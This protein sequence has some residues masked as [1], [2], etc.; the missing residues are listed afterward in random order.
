MRQHSRAVD[1]P[2]Q[3]TDMDQSTRTRADS[4]SKSCTADGCDRALRA[5]GMCSTHYNQASTTRHKKAMVQCVVCGTH[6]AKHSAGS[7]QPVCGDACRWWVN[8]MSVK[9][10]PVPRTHRAHPE[11]GSLVVRASIALSP[12]PERVRPFVSVLCVVCH[13][14]YLARHAGKY[15]SLPCLW[16]AKGQA[17]RA[18]MCGAYVSHVSNG[19]IFERDGWIC[20]LCG[21]LVDRTAR[22]PDPKAPTLDHVIALANGG[23]HEPS[24][25]QLACFQCNCIK[26]DR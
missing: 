17:R 7:R 8:P 11:Y 1:D 18:R 4:P 24:N 25:V 5:K 19:M 21:E 15:C 2:S 26:G 23:T 6:V 13:V 20:Q 22:V 10:C 12:W 16:K 9:V 3:R 14:P